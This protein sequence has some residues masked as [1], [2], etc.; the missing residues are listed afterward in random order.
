MIINQDC[1]NWMNTQQD[2]SIDTIIFSPPYNKKGLRNNVRTS[3]TLW[4]KANIDYATYNDSMPEDEYQQWQINIMN[5][6]YRIIK[7]TG[8]IFYQHKI[9]SWNRKSSHPIEWLSKCSAQF[10]QEIVW[11]RKNTMAM[12]EHY[13]FNTTERIYWFC[14]DKPK[15]YK[16]QLQ[17][18]YKSDVWVI[19]PAKQQGHPAPFPQQLVENCLLLTTEANDIVYD[20]FLGSGTTLIVC[21]NLNR[22]GIGTEIDE[23]YINLAKQRL[24]NQTTNTFSQL[25][26][27][28]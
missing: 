6:C 15:V 3:T 26:T 1:I 16:H 18:E 9:R 20:P 27:G 12:D 4:A 19:P 21:N 8:S 28:K 22:K 14:K 10:Y 25:F 17:K 13:L 24:Q 11:H 7:P 2:D 23:G 5:E